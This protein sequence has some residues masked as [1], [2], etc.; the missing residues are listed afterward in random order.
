MRLKSLL[1]LATTAISFLAAGAAM[2]N[3]KPGHNPPG[4]TKPKPGPVKGVPEIDAKSGGPAL[5]AL[6]LALLLVAES[7]RRRRS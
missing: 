1:L 7:T 4:Q 3:H 5:A 6:A 2:P